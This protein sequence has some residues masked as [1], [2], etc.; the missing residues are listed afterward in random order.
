MRQLSL[1]TF[2]RLYPW[3]HGGVEALRF[4]YQLMYLLDSTP[5]FSP[6]LHLLQQVIV[7]VSGN[8][9]VWL[10]LPPATSVNLDA[11]LFQ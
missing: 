2:I 8:E 5:F 9:L 1:L 11:V 10:A 4:A 6:D 3:V 7:R